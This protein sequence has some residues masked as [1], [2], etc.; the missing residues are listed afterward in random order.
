[1]SKIYKHCFSAFFLIVLAP[2]LFQSAYAQGLKC[3]NDKCI[4]LKISLDE[5]L[6]ELPEIKDANYLVFNEK[7][8][9][10]IKNVDNNDYP[11][12]VAILGVLISIILPF[13]IDS[14][15]KKKSVRDD[16]WIRQVIYP[17]YVDKIIEF[18]ISSSLINKNKINRQDWDTFVDDN[19]RIMNIVKDIKSVFAAMDL[20]INTE[21]IGK[22]LFSNE[23]EYSKIVELQDIY[24]ANLAA[25]PPV[26]SAPPDVEEF[27][28]SFSEKS[29]NI[30]VEI[31][32]SIH[33]VQK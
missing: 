4:H 12:Y 17:K 21:D 16:F 13:W 15:N 20:E 30:T 7:D 3:N 1:M 6:Y 23:E 31:V 26:F 27:L 32:K 22:I 9:L 29:R 10:K 8:I 28:V 14:R 19:A 24:L 18:S 33:A 25:T 11:L 5:T 2:L